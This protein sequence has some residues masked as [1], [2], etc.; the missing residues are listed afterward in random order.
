MKQ[1]WTRLRYNNY[2]SLSDR[3]FYRTRTQT[4]L[5]LEASVTS[6]CRCPSPREFAPSLWGR[7]H[8]PRTECFGLHLNSKYGAWLLHSNKVQLVIW[9]F[10]RILLWACSGGRPHW[11]PCTYRQTVGDSHHRTRWMAVGYRTTVSIAR[12][13]LYRGSLPF[14]F[15][16]GLGEPRN[17]SR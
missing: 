11:N 16:R 2:W 8:A 13:A 15:Y 7:A 6:C 1:R 5:R 4:E 12:L 3:C 10:L 17:V 9:P 14:L